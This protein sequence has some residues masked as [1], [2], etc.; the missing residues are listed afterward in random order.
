LSKGSLKGLLLLVDTF[1]MDIGKL[2]AA[3]RDERERINAAINA[4]ER[5][6]KVQTS[7]GSPNKRRG[8]PP[9]SKNTLKS[10]VLP[11]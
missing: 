11:H 10:D 7:S 6:L 2:L 4:M 5:L 8:R 3:L 1:C 9:G